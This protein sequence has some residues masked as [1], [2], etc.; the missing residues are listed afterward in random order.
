MQAFTGLGFIS[1][2]SSSSIGNDKCSSSLLSQCTLT[3]LVNQ[4][5]TR[6]HTNV[7]NRW[8]GM[9]FLIK[10]LHQVLF[11]NK[12][13]GVLNIHPSKPSAAIDLL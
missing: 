3:C 10:N 7:Y 8:M 11:V 12:T 5:N 4:K 1:C 9:R 2:L 6:T 13:F